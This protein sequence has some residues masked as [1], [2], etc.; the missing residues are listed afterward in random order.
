MGRGKRRGGGGGKEVRGEG[1]V[2]VLEIIEGGRRGRAKNSNQTDKRRERQSREAAR[3]KS[4]D[5]WRWRGKGQSRV[6]Q[7]EAAVGPID[8]FDRLTNGG[9][10]VRARQLYSTYRGGEGE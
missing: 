9:Q 5:E 4:E 10:A 3:K 6:F 8:P 7:D 2:V 1:R